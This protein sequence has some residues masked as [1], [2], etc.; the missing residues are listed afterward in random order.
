M[1]PQRVAQQTLR[2]LALQQ[3]AHRFLVPAALASRNVFSTQRRLAAT[4][5]MRENDAGTSILARQRLNRPVAPHLMIYKAQITWYL[6]GLNRIT[7]CLLSG[8]FYVFGALY[9]VAP[10]IG[11]HLE[12]AVLAAAF[13]KW[14][15]VLKV[16]AKVL[17][18]LPFTFHSFNG[19]RH[20]TWDTASLIDNKKV[21]Q[22]GWT[23]VG[24]TVVSAVLLAFL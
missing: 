20:L 19:V 12:T 24:M 18:A 23:V 15:A 10:Y 2:R 11:W 16:G 8:G 7:G 5:S 13:A 4:E 21:V 9:L 22:T 14:P 3:P 6:S 17:V 1:L